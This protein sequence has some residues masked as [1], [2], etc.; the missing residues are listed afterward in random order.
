MKLILI[1]IIGL[2]AS[3]APGKIKSHRMGWKQKSLLA[4]EL[5]NDVNRISQKLNRAKSVKPFSEDGRFI[6]TGEDART[7]KEPFSRKYFEVNRTKLEMLNGDITAYYRR[8]YGLIDC[9]EDFQKLFFVASNLPHSY[10]KNLLKTYHES[11]EN[12]LEVTGIIKE[13]AELEEMRSRKILYR[14]FL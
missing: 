5:I 9:I 1:A 2:I 8:L 4:K 11:I 14:Y 6:L 13:Q 10:K 7:L 12:A 3:F